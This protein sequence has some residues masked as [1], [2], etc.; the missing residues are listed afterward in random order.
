MYWFGRVMLLAQRGLIDDDPVI[1][2]LQD[3]AS[4]LS[5]GIIGITLFAAM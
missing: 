4:W 2:A 3:R 5:L 1:F